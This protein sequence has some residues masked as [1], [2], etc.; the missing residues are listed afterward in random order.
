MLK[1]FQGVKEDLKRYQQIRS[2]HNRVSEVWLSLKRYY[3]QSGCNYGTYE[4]MKFIE[5]TYA[6]NEKHQIYKKFQYHV[7]EKTDLLKSLV[8][9]SEGFDSDKVKN[10]LILASHLNTL[11]NAGLVRVDTKN[12]TISMEMGI[13]L[14]V[15]YLYE[16]EIHT[17]CVKHFNLSKDIVWAFNRLLIFDEDPVF[18]IV[19]LMKKVDKQQNKTHKQ[20]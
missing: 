8:W 10:I 15:P 4:S 16:D 17:L 6:I 1:I 19:D 18:I 11:M 5:T 7:D 9:I 3:E 13:S 12:C 14:L 2:V 20:N